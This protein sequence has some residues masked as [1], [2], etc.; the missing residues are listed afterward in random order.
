[1]PTTLK[2]RIFTSVTID[3]GLYAQK[4]GFK[5]SEAIDLGFTLL[6]MP[7]R[8]R[9]QIRSNLYMVREQNDMPENVRNNINKALAV[10][11]KVEEK[12]DKKN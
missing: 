1:M 2:N 6:T 5:S 7:K 4:K 10:L 11:E 8:F 3:N 9:N 12:S